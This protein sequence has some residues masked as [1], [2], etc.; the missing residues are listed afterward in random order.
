MFFYGYIYFFRSLRNLT[1]T[2]CVAGIRTR[3]RE[4]QKS[5]LSIYRLALLNPVSD[6]PDRLDTDDISDLMAEIFHM[7]VDRAIVEVVVVPHDI[8]HELFPLHDLFLILDQISEDGE[9]RLRGFD[10][11]ISDRD[12]VV[13]Y[14]ECEFPDRERYSTPS[15]R[16]FL[17]AL[18]DALDASDEFAW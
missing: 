5:N 16:R 17:E 11:D 15:I 13:I 2:L 14:V 18:E 3:L 1:T 6:S 8:L 7:R 10:L 12:P 9:F 4:F